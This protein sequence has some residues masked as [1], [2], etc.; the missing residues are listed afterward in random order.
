MAKLL[1]FLLLLFLTAC[2][3]IDSMKE[4]SVIVTVSSNG[5]VVSQGSGVIT[6]K[7]ILTAAHVVHGWEDVSVEYYDGTKEEVTIEKSILERKGN[8][9][10]YDIGLLSHDQNKHLK[11]LIDC[12]PVKIQD[13][14]FV[15][16]HP[17]NMSWVMTQGR[18]TSTRARTDQR[19]DAWIHTDAVFT[20]GSSGGPVFNTRGRII[21]IVSHMDMVQTHRV[22]TPSGFGFAVSGPEI[23]KFLT[24]VN[25]Q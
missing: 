1:P 15:V 7:G 25:S 18:V 9:V 17:H 19:D 21:G 2:T 12:K 23:C 14:V 11:R 24:S 13:K 20:R 22:F 5:V 8:T 6:S 4:S 3:P 10:T 16:G